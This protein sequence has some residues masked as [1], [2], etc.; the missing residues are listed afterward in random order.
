MKTTLLKISFIFL[1]LGLMGAGC[2]KDDEILWE[3]SPESKTAEIQKEVDGIEFSFC[4]LNEKGESATVFIEGENFS[5]NFSFK[6]KMQD[7]IVATTEFISSNFFR[8]YR[9]L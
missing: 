3:I 1:L 2:E 4:L 9:S 5:F 8:V 7:T 6:N